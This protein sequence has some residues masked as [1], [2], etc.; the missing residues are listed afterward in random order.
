MK[1]MELEK[2]LLEMYLPY[3]PHVLLLVSWSVGHSF[4][5]RQESYTAMLLSVHLLVSITPLTYLKTGNG[6]G[7][8]DRPKLDAGVVAAAGNQLGVNLVIKCIKNVEDILIE[9]TFSII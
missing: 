2:R 7:R 3:S 9:N 5:K 4:L 6:V 8:V 1:T